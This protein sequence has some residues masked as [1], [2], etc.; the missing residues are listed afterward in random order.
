M[1][2]FA[3]CWY[4]LKNKLN[5][6]NYMKW[7]DNFLSR[8]KLF[9]LVIFTNEPELFEKYKN[10]L[11]KVVYK[12]IEELYNYK[13]KEKW[14]S[15]HKKNIYL[16]NKIS[17]EVNMIWSEKISFVKEAT[18]HFSSEWYGWCDIG[19]FRGRN[20]DIPNNDI[21]HWPNEIIINQL[22]KNKIHYGVVS[23]ASNAYK[24]FMLACKLNEQGVPVEELSPTKACIS[25][26]LFMCYTS[27]IDW[28]FETYQNKLNLYFDNNYL[29]K[30][31]QVILLDCI[32]NNGGHFKLYFE[33]KENYDSW[34]MFQRILMNEK[35]S[36][37]IPLYNGIEFLDDCIKSVKKQS[38]TTWE[39]L[40]GVNGYDTNSNIFKK[41][42]TY[43]TEFIKVY[44][45][46]L[47]GCKSR[48]LNLLVEKATSKW[49][50]LLDIDDIWLPNK[51]ES[52][53]QH[54]KNYDVI[55]TCC[56]YFGNVTTI[57]ILPLKDLTVFDF[58]KFN[59]IIN[60]SCLI[61]TELAKWDESYKLLED[62]ELWLRLKKENRRFYNVPQIQVKHRIHS[63]SIFNNQNQDRVLKQLQQI[64]K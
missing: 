20:D 46:G 39:L 1:I 9:N 38:Y 18:K 12:P 7:A 49:I 25:G 54:I 11:I 4:T 55:G 31:D 51:L 23:S 48:A 3:T 42:K 26:G 33:N 24:Y 52:Q 61:K 19:Y 45:L 13:Y 10:P 50:A 40:I 8:C 21:L 29:V 16:N 41:A 44:D 53:I 37:L 57:P 32:A 30:D 6:E 2:T 27:K 47:T 5:K 60:S 14:I 63:Q 59:P 36:I 56:Q 34:F 62:Y 43:E 64:Y 22:D 28:W 35:I 15:N 58:T 17:W